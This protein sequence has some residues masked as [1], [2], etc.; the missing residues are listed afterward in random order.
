MVFSSRMAVASLAASLPLASSYAVGAPS[1]SAA[2]AA[3]CSQLAAIADLIKLPKL[4]EDA[5]VEEKMEEFQPAARYQA[6]GYA[7]L[8]Q[9]YTAKCQNHNMRALMRAPAGDSDGL[10]PNG[11][12]RPDRQD[13]R[14]VSRSHF[15]VC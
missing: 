14:Y 15:P 9:A 5:A 6:K 4:G 3:R 7:N 13:C 12:L 11:S 8:M 1:S 2:A 10:M